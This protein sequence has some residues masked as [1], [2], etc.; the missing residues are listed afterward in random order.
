[1]KKEENLMTELMQEYLNQAT[2]S[3]YESHTDHHSDQDM[4]YARG[5]H[6]EYD[7]HTDEDEDYDGDYD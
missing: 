5:G 2:G 4:T 7:N 1:L 6:T 3:V